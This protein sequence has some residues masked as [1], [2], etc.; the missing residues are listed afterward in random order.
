[1][2]KIFASLCLAP[3]L[4]WGVVFES[5][6][7][8]DIIP[9]VNEETWVFL[10]VDNT[11]I[12]SSQYLGSAQWRNHIRGKAYDCGYSN[13][14]T[15]L[16]LDKFWLFVQYFVPVRLVDPYAVNVIEQLKESK[17]C[18]FALTARDAIESNHTQKQL[19]STDIALSSDP[20]PQTLVLPAARLALLDQGVIYC[21]EN[22]KSEALIAFFKEIGR[23]PK[24]IVVVDDRLDQIEGL[25]KSIEALGIEFVGM[26]FS[27]ADKRVQAFDG[28]IADVQFSYL[29]KIVTDEEANEMLHGFIDLYEKEE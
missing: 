20:F 17:T 18:V 3:S 24:K 1:M 22:T 19:S 27:A 25:E 9:H 23:T 8:E 5:E 21:G 14:E 7:M 26:R 15:E 2:K 12:E 11:L 16:A 28:D 13:G 4:L 29:P 6:R 10:D